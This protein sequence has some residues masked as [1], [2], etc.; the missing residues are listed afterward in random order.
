M[1]GAGFT[2]DMIARIRE[3]EAMRNARKYRRAK[4][5]YHIVTQK[6]E[7]HYHEANAE[8]LNILRVQIKKQHIIDDWK[9]AIRLLLSLVITFAIF[10]GLYILI[11]E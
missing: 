8:E 5:N 4:Q 3:N 10:W 6:T 11:T 7:L 9:T 2:L 1:A